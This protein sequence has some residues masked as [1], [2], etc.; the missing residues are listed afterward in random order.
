MDAS[1]FYLA[2]HEVYPDDDL[3]RVR[4]CWRLKRVGVG[5]QDDSLLIRVD[6]PFPGRDYGLNADAI[7]IVALQARLQGY[8]LFPI[9]KWP[10]YVYVSAC[11]VSD[12]AL[13]QHFDP[14]EVMMIGWAELY[15]SEAEARKNPVPPRGSTR[16]IR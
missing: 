6:P 8:S 7:T 4:R 12:P 1:E 2:S 14:S 13:R 10:T 3:A 5:F 16:I 11:L 15:P 9:E